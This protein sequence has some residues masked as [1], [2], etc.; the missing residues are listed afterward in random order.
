MSELQLIL[1][2]LLCRFDDICRKNGIKY[3][4]SGGT[5][6]G[7]LRHKGFI[8]WDDDVDVRMPRKEYEKLEAVFDE[9]KEDDSIELVSR[10]RYPEQ[11]C[12]PIPRVMDMHTTSVTKGRM[13]DGTPH[14]V[15]LDILILDPIP[16]DEE[17]LLQWKK[18]HYVYC[19]LLE[20]PLQV[21]ARAANWEGIDIPYYR[22]IKERADIEGREPVL[23]ELEERLFC[24]DEED[25]DEYC[26]RFGATWLGIT[27]IEWYGEPRDVQFE[28]RVFYAASKAE[29]C[30]YTNYGYEWRYIPNIEKRT[31]H[32]TFKLLDVDSG[33]LERE[34]SQFV[35]FEKL[36]STHVRYKNARI[37]Y[38]ELKHR[39]CADRVKPYV[40]YINFKLD[41]DIRQLGEDYFRQ[42]TAE[43]LALFAEYTKL[44]MRMEF[45][46][47]KIYIDLS[48]RN[49]DLLSY[50]CYHENKL[51]VLEAILNI[52]NHELGG[53]SEYQK[54]IFDFC[55]D[56][57]AMMMNIDVK[58]FDAADALYRKQEEEHRDQL[59]MVKARIQ[60]DL[61]KAENPEDYEKIK[62]FAEHAL[63]LYPGNGELLKYYGDA[64][65]GTGDTA[66]AAELYDEALDTI[67]NGLLLVELM[68]KGVQKAFDRMEDL[69]NITEDMGEDD[70][71]DAEMTQE[72]ELIAT[73]E[74]ESG[75]EAETETETES[76]AESEADETETEKETE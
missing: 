13:A 27:P 34:Y 5:N 73:T 19:E 11:Y 18:D 7:A 63:T 51:T 25:A 8:P 14:G 66:K 61:A 60:I 40:H 38:Y 50:L 33:N 68:E 1:Y 52:R 4:L 58:E 22:E 10:I 43:G 30:A 9:A 17:R 23:K 75:G 36:Y 62:A 45:F 47:N 37:N 16:R 53:L 54:S 55:T 15:F 6:L 12:S 70:A 67:N 26:M 56:A 32:T 24:F 2:G 39:I 28:D 48:D 76:E 57:I 31:G 74:R 29:F 49:A 21:A 35:D 72:D 59:T 71:D 3:Y 44:Q 20:Q 65:E 41:R 64:Y 42:N 69:C 46:R